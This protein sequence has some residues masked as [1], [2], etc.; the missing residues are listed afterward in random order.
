MAPKKWESRMGS[1]ALDP[2]MIDPVSRTL[3]IDRRNTHP[4][5]RIRDNG[6]IRNV[7]KRAAVGEDIYPKTIL[8]H[9][10][11]WDQKRTLYILFRNGGGCNREKYFRPHM[12]CQNFK[13]EKGRFAIGTI[14]YIKKPKRTPPFNRANVVVI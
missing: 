2:R 14:L 5:M 10:A 9:S 11:P 1:K 8:S 6:G 7:A 4:M 13:T 3:D 12:L